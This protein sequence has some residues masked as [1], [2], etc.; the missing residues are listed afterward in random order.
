MKPSLRLGALCGK[1]E[2]DAASDLSVP[3]QQRSS[4]VVGRVSTRPNL[5]IHERDVVFDVRIGQVNRAS[6]VG[7]LEFLQTAVDLRIGHRKFQQTAIELRI[8]HG[9]LES[10]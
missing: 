8:G 6:D 5:E 2:S 9:G 7:S 3:Q 4:C 1:K 10:V